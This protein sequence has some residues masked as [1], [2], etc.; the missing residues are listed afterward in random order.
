MTWKRYSDPRALSHEDLIRLGWGN[1]NTSAELN[2]EF[3][4]RVVGDVCGE[5]DCQG[6]LRTISIVG[7]MLNLWRG[8][9]EEGKPLKKS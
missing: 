8:L 1:P 3:H 6:F 9:D 5:P 7:G 2:Q 4:R